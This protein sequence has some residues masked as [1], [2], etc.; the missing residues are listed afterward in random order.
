[1]TTAQTTTI[2]GILQLSHEEAA[3]IIR[4]YARSHYKVSPDVIE[5]RAA[6]GSGR[7]GERTDYMGWIE[8]GVDA[9]MDSKRWVPDVLVVEFKATKDDNAR[10]ADKWFRKY[11]DWGMGTHRVRCCPAGLLDRRDIPDHWGHWEIVE[12]GGGKLSINEII[13]PDRIDKHD[14]NR[15]LLVALGEI[16]RQ[17]KRD[18]IENRP[19]ANHQ[20]SNA[21]KFP[22]KL[23]EVMRGEI[24]ATRDKGIAFDVLWKCVPELNGYAGWGG[25]KNQARRNKAHKSFDAALGR[26]I[27]GIKKL[28]Q[29][30]P[31]IYKIDSNS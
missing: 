31:A 26:Q 18:A 3:P 21:P 16:R 20:S 13:V 7:I 6:F 12:V 24:A 10:D 30:S 19:Q 15:E 22:D 8:G 2:N 17:Q 23:V 9:S 1:M 27:K 28:A 25:G 11:D 4:Q 5:G 29:E 14:R